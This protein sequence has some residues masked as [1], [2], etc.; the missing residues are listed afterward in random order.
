MHPLGFSGQICNCLVTGDCHGGKT[1]W[2]RSP[3]MDGVSIQVM[4]LYNDNDVSVLLYIRYL[5]LAIRAQYY[6]WVLR[7]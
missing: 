1:Q 2:S 7:W 3:V 6:K 5:P 4:L